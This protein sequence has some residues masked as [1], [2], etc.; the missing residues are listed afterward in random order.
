[1]AWR[2]LNINRHARISFSRETRGKMAEKT[3]VILMKKD[4]VQIAIDRSLYE[5]HVLKGWYF[6]GTGELDGD[7]N[8]VQTAKVIETPGH[9]LETSDHV[10][11]KMPNFDEPP[12]VP[13]VL[14]ASIIE[15]DPAA[16]KAPAKK[17]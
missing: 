9:V 13:E 3:V 12:A 14:P 8:V 17:K 7:G 1:M 2:F 6:V 15:E 5:A 16:V 11:M 10:L 4:G